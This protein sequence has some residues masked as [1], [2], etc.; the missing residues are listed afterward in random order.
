MLKVDYD[1]IDTYVAFQYSK[2]TLPNSPN[3]T[4]INKRVV[5]LLECIQVGYSS[6][7]NQA[8]PSH[9]CLPRGV[10]GRG[11]FNATD[12][13]V[14]LEYVTHHVVNQVSPSNSISNLP[15]PNQSLEIAINILLI[16]LISLTISNRVHCLF[17]QL[18]S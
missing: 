10:R 13:L 2:F 18:A 6:L 1:F 17:F 11:I 15:K 8:V 7:V 3:L 12:G 5:H 14:P 9:S 16:N 4:A